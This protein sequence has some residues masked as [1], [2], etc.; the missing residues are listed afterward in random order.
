MRIQSWGMWENAAKRGALGAPLVGLL[1]CSNPGVLQLGA[2][3]GGGSSE[4]GASGTRAESGVGESTGGESPTGGPRCWTADPGAPAFVVAVGGSDEDGQGT[5]TSPWASLSYAVAQVPD[6]A[7]IDVTPGEYVGPQDLVGSFD[8]GITVRAVPPYQARLRHAGPVLKLAQ[9]QGITVEGFDIAHSGPGAE[10]F[11]VHVLDELGPPGGEVFTTRIV[12]RDNIIH[13]SF[14]DDLLRIDTGTAA[15]TLQGNVLYN[16]GTNN[17]H[18]DI[19]AATNVVVRGNVFFNDFE[20]SGRTNA[21][22]TASFVSVKDANGAD[23]GIS[24]ASGVQ[25]D[26][27]IFMGWQ[28]SVATNFVQLAENGYAF[29]EARD[30]VVQNNLMLGDGGDEMRA[31]LGIKGATNVL[32]RSNTVVGNIPASA[33]AFRLNVEGESPANEGISFFNNVWS[34]PEGTMLDL[35]D[36]EFVSPLENFVLDTNV[37]WNGGEPVPQDASDTV[38]V[39]ADTHAIVGDPRIPVMPQVNPVWDADTGQFAG[40]AAL[41]CDAFEE[42]VLRHGTPG[43][44]DVAAGGALVAEQPEFDILGQ[45]RDTADV[46]A[47]SIPRP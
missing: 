15:V 18:V 2:P 9:A 22:D 40:G 39:D 43:L 36:T 17:E 37:Y 11:V 38:N 42:L 41:A 5:A 10:R 20:A 45:V 4:T 1:A 27:N 34:A 25:I 44:R 35:T 8:A 26:G 31:P 29:Y 14:N 7:I 12:L 24:G 47:V 3:Q 28:G 21:Q 46:G 6:G 19:N 33:F 23:D 13:D 16:Q 30:V 32:V